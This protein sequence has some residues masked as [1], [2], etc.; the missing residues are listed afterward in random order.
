M[1]RGFLPLL[2][3][4]WRLM[5]WW[6]L[7]QWTWQWGGQA[8]LGIYNYLSLQ[9]AFVMSCFISYALCTNLAVFLFR[10]G[11]L[12]HFVLHSEPTSRMFCMWSWAS[13]WPILDGSLLEKHHHKL[14]NTVKDIF[15]RRW[16]WTQCWGTLC[17]S[18]YGQP[19]CI[20]RIRIIN[21]QI[22]SCKSSFMQVSCIVVCWKCDVY[23]LQL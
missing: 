2:A 8:N 12:W 15:W 1:K 4:H 14:Y 5:K 3:S 16:D 18:S 9:S 6:D 23:I 19:C 10:Y 13:L 11:I 22:G 17:K 21:V 7:G 20:F